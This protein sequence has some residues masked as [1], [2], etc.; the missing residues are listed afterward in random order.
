MEGINNYRLF[1]KTRS[2]VVLSVARRGYTQPQ[3]SLRTN[4]QMEVTVILSGRARFQVNEVTFFEAVAGDVVFFNSMQPHRICDVLY[5]PCS[6]L[7]VSF[8]VTAFMTEDYFV[9]D[10]ATT[11]SFFANINSANN[12]IRQDTEFCDDIKNTVAALEKEMS[13]DGKTG[14]SVARAYTILLFTQIVRHYIRQFKKPEV[15]KIPHYAD[16]QNAMIYISEHLSENITLDDLAKVANM[17]KTYFSTMFK[18]IAGKTVW[19]YIL[20]ARVELAISYLV[21][22]KADYNITEICGLCGFNNAAAFNKTFKKMTGKTPSEFK[23][24]KY[25]S[26]FSE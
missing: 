1:S 19:D 22:D 21:K 13:K 24:S 3:S 15:K 2:S 20:S 7:T 10:K 14:E 17:N 4:P 8:D 18:K 23:K 6:L 25:N 9:F 11:D 16:I 5:A 26:C 12:L